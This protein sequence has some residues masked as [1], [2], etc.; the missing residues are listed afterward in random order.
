[1]ARL[2]G[3]G[4]PSAQGGIPRE[5]PAINDFCTLDPSLDAVSLRFLSLW[6]AINRIS[7]PDSV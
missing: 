3:L 7:L 5:D 4:S 2:A 6:R 1:M